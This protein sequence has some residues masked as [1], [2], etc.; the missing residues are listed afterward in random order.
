MKSIYKF[1]GVL[2]AVSLVFSSC[3]SD[4]DDK[5]EES[6]TASYTSNNAIKGVANAQIEIPGENI[7]IDNMFSSID[8]VKPISSGVLNFNRSYIKL[9]GLTAKG[10]ILKGFTVNI[11]GVKRNFGDVSKDFDL[12]TNDDLKFLDDALKQVVSQR[13]L[14]VKV[15]YT[16][17]VDLET[18]DNVKL[19]I[20]FDGTFKYW[21]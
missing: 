16:P 14:T 4:D 1:L 2:L 6:F 13:N 20:H 10:A 9:T 5:T 19:I 11:N 18:G 8:Y 15:Q 17:T 7:S 3:G 12:A 21:K